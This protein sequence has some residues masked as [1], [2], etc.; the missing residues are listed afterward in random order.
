MVAPSQPMFWVIASRS[1]NN[2][3]KIYSFCIES[4][5]SSDDVHANDEEEEDGQENLLPCLKL[6][7]CDGVERKD[8]YSLK[9]FI[10]TQT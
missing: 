7:G 1:F 3:V 10:G 6:V 9:T 4:N 5:L 8:V 2:R